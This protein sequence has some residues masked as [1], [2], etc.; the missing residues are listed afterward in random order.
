MSDDSLAKIVDSLVESGN[1][2]EN[3]NSK[4]SIFCNTSVNNILSIFFQPN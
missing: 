2:R 4:S 1:L 3:S